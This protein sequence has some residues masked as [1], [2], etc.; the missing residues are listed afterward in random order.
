MWLQQIT[1]LLDWDNWRVVRFLF[2]F[3]FLFGSSALIKL[4][5]YFSLLHIHFSLGTSSFCLDPF[6]SLSPSF[7]RSARSVPAPFRKRG[8]DGSGGKWAE[9]LLTYSPT[10]S[11]SPRKFEIHKATW[12]TYLK[13][14]LFQMAV[15]LFAINIYQYKIDNLRSRIFK[16]QKLKSWWV[17]YIPGWFACSKGHFLVVHWSD[18][19]S[20]SF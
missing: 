18:F 9:K 10:P 4:F 19:F 8:W 11:P 7:L 1:Y 2:F 5:Y 12:V 15:V 13:Y 3:F 16:S 20:Q 17:R 14:F 6:A